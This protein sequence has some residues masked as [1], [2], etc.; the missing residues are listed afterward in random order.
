MS[1]YWSRVR[2]AVNLRDNF[3]CADCGKR[4]M[5]DIHHLTYAHRGHELDHLEDLI[6]LCPKCHKAR[7]SQLKALTLPKRFIK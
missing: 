6:S 1:D 3:R 7:H 2:R 4:G 5:T